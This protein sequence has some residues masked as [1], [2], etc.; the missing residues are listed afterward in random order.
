MSACGDDHQ[1]DTLH[2]AATFGLKQK[3]TKCA[4]D[5]QDQQL[6]AEL[7]AGDL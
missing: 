2:E 4:T 3:V 6:L 1:V 7:S 5:L